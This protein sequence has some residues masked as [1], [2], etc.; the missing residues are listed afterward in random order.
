LNLS[1][2]IPRYLPYSFRG[3]LPPSPTLTRLDLR[4]TPAWKLLGRQLLM[5]GQK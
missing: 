5:V 3:M 4:A 1:V 2:I